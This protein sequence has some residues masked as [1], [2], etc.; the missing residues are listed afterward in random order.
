MFAFSV[1]TS[2][3]SLE[4]INVIEEF[5]Q[6]VLGFFQQATK[7]SSFV[8]STK[9]N[10]NTYNISCAHETIPLHADCLS[11]MPN[12]KV[13]DIFESYN[14]SLSHCQLTGWF[15]HWEISRCSRWQVHP[16]LSPFTLTRGRYKSTHERV[17]KRIKLKYKVWFMLSL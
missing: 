12:N 4:F 11:I 15:F 14:C 1:I 10:K 2:W 9:K 7:Q 16:R 3:S 8:L 5:I 13:K 17:T 6:V